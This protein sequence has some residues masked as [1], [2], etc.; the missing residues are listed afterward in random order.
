LICA[1]GAATAGG[2]DR[3]KGN[4]QDGDGVADSGFHCG[5][6]DDSL[7]NLRSVEKRPDT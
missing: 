4:T 1:V 3:A 2:R 6:S 7:S 5:F